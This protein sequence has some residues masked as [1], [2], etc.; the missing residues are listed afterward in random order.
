MLCFAVVC[1]PGCVFGMLLLIPGVATLPPRKG[2]FQSN[3][4]YQYTTIPGTRWK[5]TEGRR[6]GPNLTNW[7]ATTLHNTKSTSQ[8]TMA[9]PITLGDGVSKLRRAAS[10]GVF[11]TPQSSSTD[12]QQPRIGQVLQPKLPLQARGES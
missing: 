6:G 2:V 10:A 11:A 9:T 7:N 12:S 4:H 1:L 8:L 3:L 5:G